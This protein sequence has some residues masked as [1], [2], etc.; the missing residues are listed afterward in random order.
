[1]AY[2]QTSQNERKIKFSGFIDTYYTYDFNEPEDKNRQ[3]TTQPARHNEAN[4]NW[5]ILQANY[6][7]GK[8]KAALALHTGTFVRNN[9]IGEPDFL[10]NIYLAN[11]SYQLSNNL[12]VT[13]GIREAAINLE[14]NLSIDNPFYS[15]SFAADIMPYYQSGLAFKWTP[16]DK[17]WADLSIINGFQRIQDNNS[18]KSLSFVANYHPNERLEIGYG[19]YIG[20]DN[21][22]SLQA[23]VGIFNDVY[24]RYAFSE[25][26]E[27]H[28]T[29][30]YNFLEATDK[31]GW[32]TATEFFIAL[33]Y[34][35]N[36]KLSVTGFFENYHDPNQIFVTTNTANGFQVNTASFNIAYRPEENIAFRLEFK[37]FSA[38]DQLFNSR[39][40]ELKSD[41][42]Y[43]TFSIATKF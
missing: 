35:I 3:F 37:V 25:K 32:L 15:R 41:N 11:V 26:V 12:L 7:E 43:V 20:N 29:G 30:E 40:A 22:D 23:Q 33:T 39:N 21:P 13:A 18:A 1:M 17:F 19:N 34:Y 6:E 28:A 31:S 14:G 5:A 2:T 27:I 4:L 42:A 9:Y 10:Q 16:N 24:I 38:E 36:Q 8:I